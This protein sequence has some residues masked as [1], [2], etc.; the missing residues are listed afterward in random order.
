MIFEEPYN[1]IHGFL[2][3]ML[4][5]S[6]NDFLV[7]LKI[8]IGNKIV[9]LLDSED[10]I[11]IAKCA[12]VNRI[13]YKHIE[14]TGFFPDGNFSIEVSSPGVEEPLKLQRQ[15]RKNIGREVEV[16]TGESAITTGKL[17]DATA[18][19]ITILVTQGKGKKAIETQE[20]I[21]FENI[22]RTTVL[23]KF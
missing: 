5:E 14:E 1:D 6:G 19:F 20:K 21:P 11:N 22:K 12:Q 17:L 3:K 18:D 2:E 7:D 15:Y 23:V 8:N 9:V 4:D 13:L 10:G 16:L